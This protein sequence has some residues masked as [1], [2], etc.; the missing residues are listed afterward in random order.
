[1]FYG[2]QNLT[3]RW[4]VNVVADGFD[5][6]RIETVS[7]PGFRGDVEEF[8]IVA[9]SSVGPAVAAEIVPQVLDVVEF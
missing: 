1:L 4:D 8:V 3:A 7:T 5:H 2:S 6:F 9:K